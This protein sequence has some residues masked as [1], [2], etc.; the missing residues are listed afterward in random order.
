MVASIDAVGYA[1]VGA[2]GKLTST[3]PPSS[4]RVDL[5][6]GLFEDPQHRPVV[7]QHLGDEPLDSGLGRARGEPLEQPRP[8]TAALML[9]G[10]REGDFCSVRFRGDA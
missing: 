6:A 2:I 9:V 5:E 3:S 1:R 4:S 7:R 10:H 8:D